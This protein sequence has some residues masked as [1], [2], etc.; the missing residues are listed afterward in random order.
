MRLPQ[1]K[2]KMNSVQIKNILS[3][4][5]VTKHYFIDV[6]ASDE[7]PA[8]ILRY[9]ACFIC[10]VDKSTKPG[11]HWLAFYLTADDK[12]EF[13]DSYGNEPSFFKGPISSF[14]SR[15]SQV[16]FNPVTLQSNVSAVCG[17]Y[18]IYYLYCR[19][20]GKAL[21]NIVSQFVTKNVCN[22]QLVYNFVAKKFHV[23]ANFYQ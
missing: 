6:F 15:F 16:T 3:R 9:P 20:R 23:Y 12:V 7:L 5:S 13:F 10:N 18:C 1:L 2:K 21:E 17:Q 4:D 22:D 14:V 19:C 8:R 11:S